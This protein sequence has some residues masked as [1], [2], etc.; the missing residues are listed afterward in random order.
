MRHWFYDSGLWQYFQ[1]FQL[2]DSKPWPSKGEIEVILRGKDDRVRKCHCCLEP[3]GQINSY[4]PMKARHLKIFEF[5]VTVIFR[6]E[7]RWCLRC[8]KTRSEHI[9]WLSDSSPHLTKAMATWINRLT[10]MSAVSSVAM[11]ESIDKMTC[12][13]VDKEILKQ[14]LQGYK[15]P[16]VT[17]ISVDEVYARTRRQLKKGEDRDDLFLT[18]IIDLDT[19]KVIYVSDSRKQKALD[20]FFELLGED[21]CKRIKVVACDQHEAYSNSVRKYC[22]NAKIVWDR[23]HLVKNFNDA[24]NEERKLELLAQGKSKEAQKLLKG[25]HRYKF[26]TRADRRSKKSQRHMDE[27]FKK[28]ERM[29]K[30]EIIKE[31]FHKVFDS[32]TWAEAYALLAECYQW[33]LD[34]NAKHVIDWIVSIRNDPRFENYFTHRVTSAVSEG[35]NRVIKGLK[36]LAFGY[37]DMEYFKLK[38]LQ[39]CGYLNSEFAGKAA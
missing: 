13:R 9:D 34:I 27:V 37:K 7:K 2:I 30:L 8:K 36:W 24:L 15:I 26:L 32:Q 11:L 22:K 29:L 35:V 33:A 23:F 18:A 4:Y 6:R 10:E 12:Y 14:Y 17:R 31:H 39:R 38:I 20:Q 16:D 25:G 21:R 1:D 3:L 28:N 5:F 19:H